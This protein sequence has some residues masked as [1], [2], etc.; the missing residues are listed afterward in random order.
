V[1]AAHD[2]TIPTTT[3]EHGIEWW[4]NGG[5]SAL[6]ERL[7]LHRCFLHD[8]ELIALDAVLG[9]ARALVASGAIP[10]CLRDELAVIGCQLAVLLHAGPHV[11]SR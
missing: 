2:D 10:R 5:D 11:R 4:P 3:G 7:D 9:E 8:R 1:T 6:V